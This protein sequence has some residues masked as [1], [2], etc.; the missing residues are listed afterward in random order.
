MAN[1]FVLRAGDRYRKAKE[2]G[3]SL[4]ELQVLKDAANEL[5]VSVKLRHELAHSVDARVNKLSDDLYVQA[6]CF[7]CLLLLIENKMQANKEEKDSTLASQLAS[8]C[9]SISDCVLTCM[10]RV[11]IMLHTRQYCIEASLMWLR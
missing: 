7:K 9:C 2:E 6:N 1:A 11:L 8:S 10:I 3:R 5:Y 4:K